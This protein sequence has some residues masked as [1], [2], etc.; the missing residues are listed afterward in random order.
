[1]EL[2]GQALLASYILGVEVSTRIGLAAKGA[3]HEFGF[4]PTGIAAHFACAL[5]AG[6]L[7][8]LTAHQLTMAQ[9]IVGSTASG[10]QEFLEEGA[11]NKRIHPGWAGVAGITAA[12]LAQHGFVGPTRVYEGRFGLF[13]SHLHEKEAESDYSQITSQFGTRWSE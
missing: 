4:H 3:F 7:R 2:N 9:G 6:W 13:K 11:W 5:Q 1:M 12:A 10:S 8:G